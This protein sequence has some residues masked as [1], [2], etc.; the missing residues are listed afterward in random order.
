MLHPNSPK[1][2]RPLTAATPGRVPS[3]LISSFSSSLGP[4]QDLCLPPKIKPGIRSSS[5]LSRPNKV[6]QRVRDLSCEH[7]GLL[8]PFDMLP[9]KEH[10]ITETF[11]VWEQLADVA[12]GPLWPRG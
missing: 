6:G 9:L 8:M 11:S 12:W 5:V 4:F 10:Q 3:F 7:T 1:K 2:N